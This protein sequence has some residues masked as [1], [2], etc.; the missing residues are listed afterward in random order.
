MLDSMI[1]NPRPTRAEVSDVA[2]AVMDHA[3]AVMLSG[4]SAQ[5]LYPVEAVEMMNKII[6][7]TEESPYDDTEVCGARGEKEAVGESVNVLARDAGIKTILDISKSDSYRYIS[8]GRPE[9]DIF[10][11]LRNDDFYP[12]LFWGV[13]PIISGADDPKKILSYLKKRG[14]IKNKKIIVISGNDKIETID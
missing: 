9:A 8:Q 2:N 12:A 10:V 7:E 4:E 3:D 14:F 11:K 5:G 13:V 6:L 1:R